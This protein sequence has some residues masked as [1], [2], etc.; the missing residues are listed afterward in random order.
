LI[1][2]YKALSTLNPACSLYSHGVAQGGHLQLQCSK[3]NKPK[4]GK[5]SDNAYLRKAPA[6]MTQ[7]CELDEGQIIMSRNSKL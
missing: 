2:E 3:P 5:P 6:Q 1:T 4:T 7:R